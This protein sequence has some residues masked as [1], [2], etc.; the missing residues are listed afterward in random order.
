MS[1]HRLELGEV[2]AALLRHPAITGAVVV[3]DGD[4]LVACLQCRGA[5]PTLT[6]LTEH[7][8]PLL[9]A[10]VRIGRFRRL[11]ELPRTASGKLDRRRM[12]AAPGEEIRPR[13]RRCRPDRP[14]GG[15]WPSCSRRWSARPIEVDQRFFDAGASSLGLMRLH[16][17]LTAELGR[18]AEHRGPVRAR[19]R[20]PAGPVPRRAVCRRAGRPAAR[21]VASSSCV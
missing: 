20:P 9:P 3:R 5:T 19:H 12:L 6:E 2:E 10:Y 16:L 14:G 13:R 7:L 17:R 4:Q 18:A 8:A 1:G 21:R 15:S 11:A